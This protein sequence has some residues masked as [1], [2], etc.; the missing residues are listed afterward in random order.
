MLRYI[1]YNL[2]EWWALPSQCVVFL[3]IKFFLFSS[4]KHQQLFVSQHNRVSLRTRT[5]FQ[6]SQ[7]HFS[8]HLPPDTFLRICSHNVVNLQKRNPLSSRCTLLH[9]QLRV[10]QLL[11]L[12]V[13]THT[14]FQQSHI[15][16]AYRLCLHFF[17]YHLLSCCH[18]ATN[19]QNLSHQFSG[20]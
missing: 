13:G 11:R 1:L 9:Q 12:L 6:Q 5:S 17:Q 10:Y 8:N 15:H 4:P 7:T 2:F 3:L 18:V 14:V 19:F 16:S 20:R